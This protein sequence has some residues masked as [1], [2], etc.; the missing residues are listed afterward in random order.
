VAI[1]SYRDGIIFGLTGDD[2]TTPDL[3]VLARGTQ[4]GTADFSKAAGRLPS[5]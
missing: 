5:S 1:F 4:D 3:D 2:D